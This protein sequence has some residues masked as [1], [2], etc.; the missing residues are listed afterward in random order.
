[1]RRDT[2]TKIRGRS[3]AGGRGGVVATNNAG[4]SMVSEANERSELAIYDRS[5]LG[6]NRTKPTSI[7][8]NY[9]SRGQKEMQNTNQ[10][11]NQ[12]TNQNAEYQQQ[13]QQQTEARQVNEFEIYCPYKNEYRTIKS[14]SLLFAIKAAWFEFNN[15]T[16]D[17]QIHDV[18]FCRLSTNPYFRMHTVTNTGYVVPH[19]ARIHMQS[20][21]SWLNTQSDNRDKNLDRDDLE[22]MV[23]RR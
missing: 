19:T 8:N 10:N 22:L 12:T 15:Y 16:S 4:K 3:S 2:N 5:R 23:L 21:G 11:T 18:V 9:H 20:V 17:F 6:A 1:M 7:N 13:V 14:T